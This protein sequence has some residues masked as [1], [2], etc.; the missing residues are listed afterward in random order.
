MTLVAR[1]TFLVLVG[2]SF[3]AFFVAQRLKSTPPYI[4]AAS[5]DRYFSPNGDGQR[6]VNQFSITL[7]VA[8]DATV[9][10]VNLDGDRVK[11]L[12]E[13]VAVQRYRPLRLKWD[14][15]DDA[16]G[17]VPDGR[18]RLRVAMRN[19]GRSAT[20][21]KTMT[22][23][24]KAPD[25]VACIGFK[26]SDTKHMG[27]VISQGD[28]RVLIYVRGVSRFP[29]RFSLYR[30]DEG[31]PRKIADLPPLKGGFNRKVWDGLVDG[32]PLPPGTYL[33]QV[34]VR[35]TARN[36]GVSPAEF[37]VGAIRGRPGITVRGLAAQPP[38]RP[39]TE[40]QR[41][42]VHVDARGAAYRW[43]VR[44]VGDSAVRKRGTE[45]APV[46]AFRAPKG[47]SGVYL[48]ELRAG[49][50]H[51][52]VPFLVQA[53]KRSSVLVVVPAVSWLGTDKVDD[54]PFDGLP[55]TLTDGGTVRWPRAF[56]GDD[57]LPAGFAT[58]IAPLL[59]FLD[60]Q[61]IRYDLTSDLD[62]DLTRN[63]RASDRPG[64]LFAGSERWITR[65]LAKRLRRYVTDGGHVALFGGDT[66]LRGVRLRVFDAEDSG[67]LSRA[68][69]PTSTDP[70]GARIGKTRTLA[71]PATLSQFDGSTEYGLMEGANDLP[72]FKVLQESTLVDGKADLASVGQ[73]LT[74]EEE[75]ASVS[76]GKDP[77][78]IRPALAATQLGKGVVIRVGLPEWTSKLAD[79][80]VS[81]VTRN[82]IDILRGVQPR[83]RSTK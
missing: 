21:Q 12:A 4:E 45:T 7:R 29:T 6:D 25:P 20:I 71:A 55:N 47:P 50:W 43:R 38:L 74:P 2:A 65:T 8:D 58:Q 17:R 34:R 77:R 53:E 68:T 1:V 13:N 69:Q 14:G 15:T 35:D 66:M 5:V 67:T 61:R 32:K 62:L 78:E 57:G 30:T 31:K 22:V 41:V 42:E 36:V 10:V 63:P 60:R 73:P 79:S 40:G 23:D 52:T 59:V 51:T 39:V 48:L 76:S 75:A 37:A 81:Q 9:D 11:R 3:S 83:I 18:Y 44:R 28:R 72:G 64:V 26:C 56:V 16:G 27:N 19:E 33:V 82:I 80:N 46:L 70:F 54:R 24:T 49:R